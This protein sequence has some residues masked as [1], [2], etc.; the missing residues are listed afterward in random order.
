M[1]ADA[2]SNEVRMCGFKWAHNIYGNA[3]LLHQGDSITQNYIVVQQH[4]ALCPT[5]LTVEAWIKPGPHSIQEGGFIVFKKNTS[6]HGYGLYIDRFWAGNAALAACVESAGGNFTS[7]NA[8][9]SA[10]A[11][12]WYYVAMTADPDF[13]RLYVNTQLVD[14]VVTGFP[15]AHDN[16][17]LFI[18]IENEPAEN[19]RYAGIIDDLC[20]WDRVLTQPEISTRYRTQPS[21]LETNLVLYFD[22][23]TTGNGPGIIVTN[24]AVG[25]G[26]SNG[27]TGGIT[28]EFIPSEGAAYRISFEATTAS[29]NFDIYWGPDFNGRI[30]TQKIGAIRNLDLRRDAT[31]RVHYIHGALPG[32]TQGCCCVR[33]LTPP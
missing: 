20:I 8:G 33:A 24:K 2:A 22:M 21:G 32:N 26:V 28:T 23:D 13:L 10:V 25:Y 29:T 16:T 4:D 19:F 18:G 1:P 14:E 11:E 17:P 30:P 31:T 9:V 6:F 15:L 5:A 7:V 3:L 27:I 12:Q